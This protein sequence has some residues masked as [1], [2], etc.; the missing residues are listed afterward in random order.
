MGR[1][2]AWLEFAGETLL[3]RVVR[4]IAEVVEPIVV[5][6]G[7]DQEVPPTSVPVTLVR[8][9]V[10]HEG[11]LLGIAGGLDALPCDVDL[12]YV[13]SCD[14]PL[15]RPAW[16]RA[17]LELLGDADIAVPVVFGRE[18]PLAAVY[19]PTVAATARALLDEGRRRPVDLFERLRTVRV[20]QAQLASV[21]PGC[22]SLQNVNTPE[23]YRALLARLQK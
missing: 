17:M 22:D 8:D 14:V 9:P 10:A 7:P 1:P 3:A 13:S 4:I 11:P 2:K 19:R 21:D 5:V 18:H 12:A 15:L 23:E 20:M 16:V 6:A